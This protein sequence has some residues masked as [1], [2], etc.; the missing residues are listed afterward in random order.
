[1][2]NNWIQFGK[3]HTLMIG[4]KNT[5]NFPPY[6]R[7]K[8]PCVWASYQTLKAITCPSLGIQ[9][10]HYIQLVIPWIFLIF[11]LVF[12]DN[13]I[14]KVHHSPILCRY[15]FFLKEHKIADVQLGMLMWSQ[16]PDRRV[17][18]SN[19][20]ISLIVV[21]WYQKGR[22]LV[23]VYRQWKKRMDFGCITQFKV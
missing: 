11:L 15:F 1:M 8:L 16:S 9:H 17:S 21:K 6:H 13:L 2:I 14:S 22:S 5:T 3:S 23:W 7:K 18:F 20:K 19:G 12:R 4:Y 10:R